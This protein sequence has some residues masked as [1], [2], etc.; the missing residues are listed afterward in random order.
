MA[1]GESVRRRRRGAAARM[2]GVGVAAL[3][4]ALA[5]RLLA[6]PPPG[7]AAVFEFADPSAPALSI[8]AAFPDDATIA[9]VMG[10]GAQAPFTAT[11]FGF[12]HADG[13]HYVF[14]VESDDEATLTI[15]GRVVVDTAGQE[16]RRTGAGAVVLEPGGRRVVVRYRQ[17]GGEHVLR[18]AFRHE[19][20]GV[21]G[22]WSRGQWRLGRRPLTPHETG[23]HQRSAAIGAALAGAAVSGLLLLYGAAAWHLAARARRRLGVEPAGRREGAALAGFALLAASGIAWGLPA[24]RDTWAPDEITPERVYTAIDFR[25]RHGWADLYPPLLFYAAAP[26]AWAV[27]L[28]AAPAG[29]SG[30]EEPGRTA[31]HAAIRALALLAAAIAA[32]GLHTLARQI[33][34]RPAALAACAAA[35]AGPVA[36]YY[37]RAGNA[38]MA[39]LALALWAC[40]W[41]TGFWRTGDS[42]HLTPAAAC[43][44]L[45]AAAKDQYAGFF[46]LV[47]AALLAGARCTSGSAGAVARDRRAWRAA[48]IGAAIWLAAW[49]V[50]GNPAGLREHLHLLAASVYPAEFPATPGGYA[51]FGIRIAELTVF[52]AGW[53]LAAAALAGWLLALRGRAWTAVAAAAAPVASYVITFLFPIRYAYDRFVLGLW[54]LGAIGVGL[55]IDRTAGS[56]AARPVRVAVAL[57]VLAAL[58]RAGA[59]TA[60]QIGDTRH[61]VEHFLAEARPAGATV[62]LYGPARYLPRVADHREIHPVV[63]GTPLAP[64]VFVVNRDYARRH[65]DDPEVAGALAALEG[66][67]LPYR[68]V[69]DCRPALPA[70]FGLLA[71]VADLGARGLTNLDKIAPPIAVYSRVPVAPFRHRPP[72][73][74]EARP[75]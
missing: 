75:W 15:D 20:T 73:G 64:D 67:A 49:Y 22:A 2:A 34:T 42:A 47:P 1:A 28:A 54:L 6:P 53:P 74:C 10:A 50:P 61:A 24:G 29:W 9:H 8:A 38:D 39:A 71:A 33:V 70:D 25:F 51:R 13:G 12:F 30:R 46:L 5:A 40:A 4:G 55:L 31:V 11:W 44:A 52:V 16:G 18:V 69:L 32:A 14:T 65:L 62:G 68:L 59:V 72:R 35:F 57:G 36:V 43:A 19:E 41:L 27:D 45:A 58:G 17:S 3:A 63:L 26:A 56:R 7:L 66:G 60:L 48:A 37:A 23:W 21:A